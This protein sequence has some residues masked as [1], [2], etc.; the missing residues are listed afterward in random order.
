MTMTEPSPETSAVTDKKDVNKM[1]STGQEN[2]ATEGATAGQQAG[3]ETS[4]APPVGPDDIEEPEAVDDVRQQKVQH[5]K[6][7]PFAVGCVNITWQD[8]QSSCFGGRKPDVDPHICASAYCCGCLGAGRV[9]N[10]AILSQTTE[11]YELTRTNQETGEVST[12][13]AKRPKL[14][15]VVGPYWPMNLFVTYPLIIGISCWTFFKA[16]IDMHIIIIIVWSVCTFLM[17][18]SLAMVACRN[19]GILYRYPERPP[20]AE[21]WRWNDQSRTYRPPKARF[22]PECQVVVEG[23]DHT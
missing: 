9:G 18:F 2:G 5:W 23:F 15:W 13:L 16:V 10:M 20:D 6:D 22:D 12:T 4:A 1:A 14:L 7:S 17:I 11:H 21:D 19:P 8:D 3:Q